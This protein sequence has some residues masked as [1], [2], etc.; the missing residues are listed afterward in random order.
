MTRYSSAVA[1]QTVILWENIRPMCLYFGNIVGVC[2]VNVYEKN[3]YTTD[4]GEFYNFG[5]NYYLD[6]GLKS[7]GA[8]L[9]GED[10]F[11]AVDGK[12]A[13][14]ATVEFIKNSENYK[15]IWLKFPNRYNKI[16]NFREL[17]N[18]NETLSKNRR[19][20]LFRYSRKSTY[21]V[22]MLTKTVKNKFRY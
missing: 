13:A 19:S 18:F 2:G 3:S 21:S 20:N 14:S 6:N 10:K 15:S 17:N 12:G 4:S 16:R 8:T 11:V 7:F 1:L 5:G 22:I 9:K